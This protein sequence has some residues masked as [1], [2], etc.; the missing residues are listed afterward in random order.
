[1][2][3]RNSTRN[4]SPATAEAIEKLCDKHFHQ[5]FWVPANETLGHGRLR[6]TYSTTTNFEDESLPAVLFFHPMFGGRYGLTA[7]N[8]LACEKGVRVVAPDR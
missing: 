7:Y 8:A 6:V 4:D 5:A 1:M 2:A 3:R